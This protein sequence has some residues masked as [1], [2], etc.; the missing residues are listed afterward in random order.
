MT[1][2]RYADYLYTIPKT[3]YSLLLEAGCTRN[4]LTSYTSND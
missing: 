1:S 2:A 4:L 3:G